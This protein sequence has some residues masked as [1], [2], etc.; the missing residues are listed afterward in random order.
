[1]NIKKLYYFCE[2]CK[3][4]NLTY[5]SKR[6]Y[7]TQQSL[8]YVI[9]TL[10]Q[11]LK[12]VLLERSSSG[13]TLTE[14]G[15]YF[16]SRC[17]HILDE[18]HETKKVLQHMSPEAS[19]KLRISL[20]PCFYNMLLHALPEQC[21]SSPVE[22]TYYSSYFCLQTLQLHEADATLLPYEPAGSSLQVTLL[23]NIPISVVFPQDHPLA[24]QSSVSISDLSQENLLL[25]QVYEPIY[26]ALF[27]S[28]P[29]LATVFHRTVS[30]PS[31][32]SAVHKCSQGQGVLLMD[33]Q[34]LHNCIVTLPAVQAV[35]LQ[36]PLTVSVYCI[37]AS[38]QP[39]PPLQSFIQGI[40]EALEKQ[41]P[42]AP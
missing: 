5:T 23:G 27:T 11:E 40:R 34:A 31:P 1:M 15:T 6:L 39:S 8:S 9:R 28:Y 25:P 10:E 13:L 18:W 7:V 32:L 26:E 16:L 41:P 20:S 22:Y 35:P 19:E 2:I 37:Y 3:D 21:D 17:T 24:R 29:K 14:Q 36:P 33:Q 42:S 30:L 4:M 38:S 12:C